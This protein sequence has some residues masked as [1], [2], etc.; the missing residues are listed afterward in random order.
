VKITIPETEFLYINIGGREGAFDVEYTWHRRVYQFA[1]WWVESD[2]CPLFCEASQVMVCYDCGGNCCPS[3]CEDGCCPPIMAPKT[4]YTSNN[5]ERSPVGTMHSDWQRTWRHSDISAVRSTPGNPQYETIELAGN[6][7]FRHN[8]DYAQADFRFLEIR[9]GQARSATHAQVFNPHL[10]RDNDQGHYGFGPDITQRPIDLYDLSTNLH[11]SIPDIEPGRQETHHYGTEDGNL[12]MFE[13]KWFAGHWPTEGKPS[14]RCFNQTSEA[15]VFREREAEAHALATEELGNL[16]AQN[17][18]LV[19]RLG[20]NDYQFVRTGGHGSGGPTLQGGPGGE[21]LVAGSVNQWHDN[22]NP[23]PVELHA[24]PDTTY[25]APKGEQWHEY[26]IVPV[27]GF[28]GRYHRRDADRNGRLGHN[29]TSVIPGHNPQFPEIAWHNPSTHIVWRLHNNI[30]NFVPFLQYNWLNYTTY[31]LAFGDSIRDILSQPEWESMNHTGQGATSPGDHLA[32]PNHVRLEYTAWQE[33][34]S[35]YTQPQGPHT[36]LADPT[37]YMGPNPVTIHNPVASIFAW[38][39][40]VPSFTLQDQRINTVRQQIGGEIVPHERRVNYEAAARLYVDFDFRITMPN[41]GTF[42]TYWHFYPA[43]SGEPAGRDRWGTPRSSPLHTSNYIGRG[44]EGLGLDGRRGGGI[45]A[46]A[47]GAVNFDPAPLVHNTGY[48]HPDHGLRGPGWIGDMQP[49][50]SRRDYANPYQSLGTRQGPTYG[51]R[52][53][54]S[55]WDVSKWIDAKYIQFPFDVYYYGSFVPYFSPQHPGSQANPEI[56]E[57]PFIDFQ[58]FEGPG[59][60]GGF[61]ATF[62][63][64]GTWITLFDN[65]RQELAGPDNDPTEFAFRIPSHVADL[66]NQEIRIVARSI[67]SP[68]IEPNDLWYLGS[69]WN[70]NAMRLRQ[71]TG[72]EKTASHH[73]TGSEQD[74]EAFHATATVL[75]VDVIGR[76]GNVLVDDNADPQWTNVFWQT[77]DQNRPLINSPVWRAIGQHYNM[78]ESVQNPEGLNGRPHHPRNTMPGGIFNRF[79]QL[80]QWHGMDATLLYTEH[81]GINQPYTLPLERNPQPQYSSQVTS[82]GY[83]FQFSVQTL[84]RFGDGEMWV[85][86]RYVLLGDWAT[87]PGGDHAYFRMFATNPFDPTGVRQMF[88]DSEVP[89][90]NWQFGSHG[91]V[92]GIGNMTYPRT[93]L[94]IGWQPNF[95]HQIWHSLADPR[96]KVNE[97]ER[98]GAS[99]TNAVAMGQN[100]RFFLGDPSFIRIP[101]ELRTHQGG[102]GTKGRIGEGIHHGYIESSIPDNWEHGGSSVI[103]GPSNETWG[104]PIASFDSTIPGSML[105]YRGSNWENAHRWHA[106]H[107]LPNSTEIIF[108][109]NVP[110]SLFEGRTDNQY[111][112]V[113]FTFRTNGDNG[114]WDLSTYTGA[115]N[116]QP[117]GSSLDAPPHERHLNPPDN[118]RPIPGRLGRNRERNFWLRPRNRVEA[119]R[120]D[121]D[122]T[123]PFTPIIVVDYSRPAPTDQT[124]IGTH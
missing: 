21:N 22:P 42:N 83:E 122:W 10:Y 9:H 94:D 81:H 3:G 45:S 48:Q 69:E 68:S 95:H 92:Q 30:Y 18:N 120:G 117:Y 119:E 40:D 97:M 100:Y 49:W 17:A 57:G 35:P 85:H 46:P 115:T 80:S 32:T 112:G 76:I 37:A 106:R 38:V 78:F 110:Y 102:P 108:H 109:D 60:P 90:A 124:T 24:A 73:S 47:S 34:S 7:V 114:L 43:Q 55:I 39:H 99:F 4:Y 70:I 58:S 20:V 28:Q 98:Q 26:E 61:N 50:V 8:E 1:V 123:Y 118:L 75:T 15:S 71:G 96:A 41:D 19:F 33:A 89:F 25:F 91:G 104:G 72:T 51:W 64:A 54:P 79:S 82:L 36:G 86:P 13:Y 44:S 74:Q 2:Y 113:N 29:P 12:S 116:S 111:I 23:T 84:G 87:H 59:H 103:G 11:I 105:N 88:W 67:N 31:E 63:E 66:V 27:S 93:D 52:Q 107:H 62:V 53:S 56:I 65:N 14:P 121:P 6:G 16:F 5:T 77:N 101:T